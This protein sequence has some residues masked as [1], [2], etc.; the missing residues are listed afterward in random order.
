M[1]DEADELAQALALSLGADPESDPAPQMQSMEAR[2]MEIVG[3]SA[4]AA[5]QAVNAAGPGGLALAIDLVLGG[6]IAA[7]AQPSKL[8]CLVRRDLGMGVGKVAAQVAHGVLGAYRVASQRDPQRLAA[9]ETTGEACIVLG[10]TGLEE[11]DRLVGSAAQAG[12]VTHVVQ[13][14]GRTEVAVGSKTVGC[15]GPGVVSEIDT[16]TGALSLF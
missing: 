8:V 2:L 9:W 13:D 15:I 3:C 10:V 5:A 11:L 1:G 12:L 16:I 14:A 4:E 6:G 7:T